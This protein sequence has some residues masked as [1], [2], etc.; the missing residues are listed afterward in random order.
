MGY[1]KYYH[2]IAMLRYILI[3]ISAIFVHI[4]IEN[5][6]FRLG[7]LPDNNSILCMYSVDE[8][9]TFWCIIELVYFCSFYLLL[10]S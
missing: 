1:L 5:L 6:N 2:I 9:I 3:T 10:Q 4:Y 7:C 8:F